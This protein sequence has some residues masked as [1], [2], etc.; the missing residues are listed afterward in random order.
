MAIL[1]LLRQ[2]DF[3]A[4][5]AELNDLGTECTKY[6][7]DYCM[8]AAYSDLMACVAYYVGLST[9]ARART[10]WDTWTSA[11]VEHELSSWKELA[12]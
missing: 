6:P 3:A 4:A 8:H 9:R 10:A 11:D 12:Q 5:Q 7:G 1:E 2:G